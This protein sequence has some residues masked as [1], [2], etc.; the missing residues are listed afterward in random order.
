MS[1]IELASSGSSIFPVKGAVQIRFELMFVSVVRQE[2]GLGRSDSSLTY[3]IAYMGCRYTL[4]IDKTT[5]EKRIG[6]KFYIAQASYD[7]GPTY[8]TT[9]F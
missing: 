9:R 5:S 7:Y 6:A 3:N 1:T 8:S 4:T 2:P